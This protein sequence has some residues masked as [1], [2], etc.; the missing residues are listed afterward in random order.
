MEDNKHVWKELIY[1]VALCDEVSIDLCFYRATTAGNHLRDVTHVSRSDYN[2][3]TLAPSSTPP[4]LK[5]WPRLC[6]QVIRQTCTL[7]SANVNLLPK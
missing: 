5:S 6:Q 1:H 7:T 4:Q 2:I 3:V